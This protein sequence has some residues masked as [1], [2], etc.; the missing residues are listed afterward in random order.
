ME[1]TNS[2]NDLLVA[3]MSDLLDAENQLL[4][5]LPKMVQA[6]ESSALKDALGEYLKI[7]REHVHRLEDIF[8]NIGQMPQHLT[9]Q[10]MKGVVLESEDTVTR[11]EKSSARDT[12]IIDVAQHAEEYEISTYKTVR[13]HAADLG[14]TKIVELFTKTLNEQRAMKFHLNELAQGMINVQSG[15]FYIPEGKFN[16]GKRVKK[17][18]A[19]D[20]SRFISEGNPNL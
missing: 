1:R 2:L 17:S 12:A 8:S 10:A 13:E 20:V 16:R 9:C 6:S 15:G 18:K 14:H 19:K 11:T 5:A 4:V 7:T 3:E